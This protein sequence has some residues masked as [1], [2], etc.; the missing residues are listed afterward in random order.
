MLRMADQRVAKR[1]FYSELEEDK[2]KYSGQLLR[3]KDV[4]KRH[5]RHSAISVERAGC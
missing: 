5:M 1:I 2:R 3:Y 4:L